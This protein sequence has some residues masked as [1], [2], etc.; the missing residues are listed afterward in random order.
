MLTLRYGTGTGEG[1]AGGACA[2]RSANANARTIANTDAVNI[3]ADR[4]RDT[5]FIA[6][7]LFEGGQK[8]P[9]GALDATGGKLV[10]ERMENY[11]ER[12]EPC[13][14][15]LQGDRIFFFNG[16]LQQ[17]FGIALTVFVRVGR[18]TEE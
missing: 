16:P 6:A 4:I 2:A 17:S 1:G 14:S 3:F 18:S 9:T 5:W 8:N 12:D 11:E 13:A 15:V 10:V 7:V